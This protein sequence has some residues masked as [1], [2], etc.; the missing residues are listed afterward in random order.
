MYNTNDDLGEI[1]LDAIDDSLWDDLLTD[2]QDLDPAP[3]SN[4]NGDTF[5]H[6]AYTTALTKPAPATQNGASSAAHLTST[7]SRGWNGSTP[8]GS[9]QKAARTQ[10]GQHPYIRKGSKQ[11]NPHKQQP[12]VN[13]GQRT[14]D[15]MFGI[16]PK[17]PIPPPLS[18][19][20]P[21][22]SSH[23]VNRAES[24][25]HPPTKV[26]RMQ[27]ED[28]DII[29][30]DFDVDDLDFVEESPRRNKPA[31]GL[32]QPPSLPIGHKPPLFQA[33]E[34]VIRNT[35]DN[36]LVES[37][38]AM[39]TEALNT[40]VYPLLYGQPARAYQQGAIQHCIFQNTLVALPTGMGKT[41]IAAV[42][43]ANYARWFPNTMSIF[44]APTK[45]LVAQQM[46]A[47]KGM[48][49][50]LYNRAG[51]LSS[52]NRQ[53]SFSS[54]WVTQMNGQTLPKKR[55]EMWAAARFVFSTPQILQND[56]K[57]GTLDVENAKR[58]VLLVIDEAHR[59]TGRYAYGESV[60]ALHSLYHGPNSAVYNSAQPCK[61]APFRVMALTATPGSKIGA[62]DDIVQ[63]LH[64]AH[65]FL[66]TEESIDVV[67]YIH[68][69]QVDEVVIELPPWLMA[70]RDCLS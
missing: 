54:D 32:N 43:M 24:P 4:S 15:S 70:A 31:P 28:D 26:A 1:D 2:V 37:T 68:G 39:D 53:A 14:L 60:D 25:M 44:L 33:R 46:Q 7:N 6:N 11:S 40:F 12:G 3:T 55:R 29:D 41:L 19:K 63:R 51:E 56:L 36:S 16:K 49:R 23:G 35:G 20:R 48:I 42:V 58:I 69:R 13:P 34:L 27:P 50:A 59:A 61:S 8:A 45:P 47:C 66:R 64:I 67:P 18:S 62:V 21:M 65:I 30:L 9:Q 38:H 57:T 10:L 5:M 22:P 17:A 52:H